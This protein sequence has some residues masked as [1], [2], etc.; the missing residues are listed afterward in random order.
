[1]KKNLYF[2]CYWQLRFRLPP[3]PRACFVDKNHNG[4][5]D[6]GEKVLKDVKVSDGLN[7]VKPMQTVCTPCPDTN[8]SDLF[9]SPSSGYK[10]GDKHYHPITAAAGNYDFGLIPYQAGIDK[11]GAHRFI[12]VSDTEIFNTTGNEAWAENIRQYAANENRLLSYIPAT[13]ATK[14]D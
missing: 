9:S 6:K 3:P 7:V 13:S 14:R 2:Q 10:A 12:Q 4:S 5:F 8:V 11:K 1:M